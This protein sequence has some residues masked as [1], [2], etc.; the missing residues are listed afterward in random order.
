MRTLAMATLGAVA[1]C[2]AIE[3]GQAASIGNGATVLRA[4]D[5]SLSEKIAF[6]RCWWRQGVRYCRRYRTGY[7]S[8]YR[9][10][11]R[12]YYAP[13]LGLILGVQ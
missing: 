12:Y 13:S 2:T 4:S 6:R 5:A 8:Y 11:P 1:L 7:A 3:S 10:H 9:A